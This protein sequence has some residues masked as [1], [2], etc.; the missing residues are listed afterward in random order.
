[1]S[2]EDKKCPDCHGSMKTIKIID[3]TANN[4]GFPL[5]TELEYAVL[6]AKRSLWS[7]LL[8]IEGKITAHMCDGWGRVL[9]YGHPRLDEAT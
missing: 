6:E 9:L 7:G 3:K 5:Y 2:S 4:A 1:V 8:P